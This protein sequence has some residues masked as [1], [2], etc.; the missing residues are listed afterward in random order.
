MDT[1][2]GSRLRKSKSP[3]LALASSALGV[4]QQTTESR[5]TPRSRAHSIGHRLP[6]PAS[7]RSNRSNQGQETERLRAKLKQTLSSEASLRAEVDRLEES[8]A[9]QRSLKL[10][11]KKR[12]ALSATIEASLR[13]EVD[14]LE[15]SVANQR[16]LKRDYKQRLVRSATVEVNLRQEIEMLQASL[17][18]ST[19]NGATLKRELKTQR[20][21][22]ASTELLLRRTIDEVMETLGRSTF[23]TS[24]LKE[25][26]KAL[27]ESLVRSAS[28]VSKLKKE[29]EVLKTTFTHVLTSERD[30]R[31][32][33]RET[34]EEWER[35]E[36]ALR[37]EI[38]ALRLAL[39]MKG[40]NNKEEK[41]AS[42]VQ[43]AIQEKVRTDEDTIAL[44]QSHKPLEGSSDIH[45]LLDDLALQSLAIGGP[46]PA[47]HWTSDAFGNRLL[48]E[49]TA[50]E[51]ATKGLQQAVNSEL[52]LAYTGKCWSTRSIIPQRSA[53]V[54]R[55][56]RL[57]VVL[58]EASG[59]EE[60]LG[61]VTSILSDTTPTISGEDCPI[62]TDP[63]LPEERIVVEGCGH[64]MCKGCLREYIGARLGEKVWPVRCPLCMAEGGRERRVQ[65]KTVLMLAPVIAGCG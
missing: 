58:W 35:V 11:Y 31:S 65:S 25:N 52:R 6:Q 32:S 61:S 13:A 34:H 36:Q 62:C 4:P 64:A 51:R 5:S 9:N 22:A 27:K 63:L 20:S 19:F 47:P 33:V 60:L 17:A 59:V 2:H 48:P 29:N 37:A 38:R 44:K 30:T 53:N 24:T 46:N 12:L 43:Q 39:E 1:L 45:I 42:C 55:N 15:G 10:D 40:N 56:L 26:I 50:L 57:L 14:Q 8:L 21:Q 23:T 28:T 3:L 18:R 54:A 49:F 7:I 16:S 41:V